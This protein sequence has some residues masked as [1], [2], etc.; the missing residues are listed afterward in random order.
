MKILVYNTYYK[1]I[2]QLLKYGLVGFVQNGVGYT[3]YIFLTWYGMDPKLV[4]AVCYPLGMLVSFVGNN[5]YTFK[6]GNIAK[7]N[8]L[9]R[10]LLVHVVAYFSNIMLIYLLSEVL[11]YNHQLVQVFCIV[12]ISIYLFLSFKYFVFKKKGDEH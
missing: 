10:Y 3:L 9:A 5:K 11:G 7:D 8:K 12:S 2:F 4:V 1:L 6:D